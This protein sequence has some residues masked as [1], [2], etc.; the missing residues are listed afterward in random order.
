MT[1]LCSV[2]ELLS[3]CQ[4]HLIIVI[5][6]T[7]DVAF[8]ESKAIAENITNTQL[9]QYIDSNQIFAEVVTS[10]QSVHASDIRTTTNLLCCRI[11]T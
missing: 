2:M 9:M 11:T 3:L 4:T 5:D 6:D 8:Q 7:S 1:F 10:S